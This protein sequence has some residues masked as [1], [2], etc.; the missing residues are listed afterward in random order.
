MT[1]DMVLQHITYTYALSAIHS[2]IHSFI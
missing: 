2:Q 1:A